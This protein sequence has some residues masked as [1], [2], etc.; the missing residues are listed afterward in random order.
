[1]CDLKA[2]A[3]DNCNKFS[4]PLADIIVKGSPQNAQE[5]KGGQRK[6]KGREQAYVVRDLLTALAVCH[7]VTPIYPDPNNINKQEFQASSPDEIAL[8]KFAADEMSMKLL[9]RD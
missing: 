8:V 1:M 6:R 4:E 9:E 3:E 5:I 2:M 7:N